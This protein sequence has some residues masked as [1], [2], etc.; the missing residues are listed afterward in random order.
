MASEKDRD[1]VL[2]LESDEDSDFSSF[3][4]LN[5]NDVAHVAKQVSVSSS[6]DK[7]KGK[8]SAKTAQSQNSASS[9][10]KNSTKNR[11]QNDSVAHNVG[12]AKANSHQKGLL[13]HPPSLKHQT[14]DFGFGQFI[15]G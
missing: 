9:V 1:D 11:P 10:M 7:K 2:S 6:V 12:S 15:T 5:P 3:E 8:A 14:K 4:P 13:K